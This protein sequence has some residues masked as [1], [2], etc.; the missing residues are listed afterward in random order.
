MNDSE[1]KNK[2]WPESS[3]KMLLRATFLSGPLAVNA[4]EEWK[5]QVNMDDHPDPGSSRLLPHLF[6]NL[7]DLNVDDPILM[8]LRGIARKNWVNNQRVL[9]SKGLPWRALSDQGIDVLLLPGAATALQYYSDY[10]LNPSTEIALL[11]RPNT[12]NTVVRQLQ[13]LGWTVETKLPLGEIEAIVFSRSFL[14]FRNGDG[15]HLR[16]LWRT[17][18]RDCP[19][20]IDEALWAGAALAQLQ[21][22]SV[23]V[24]NP[25]D[26][27]L[28]ASSQGLP[29]VLDPLFVRAAETMMVLKA[30]STVVDWS[31]LITQAQIRWQRIPLIEVL[32]YLQDALDIPI[33][34]DA[35]PRLQKTPLFQSEQRAYN[36]R[37]YK[38][39]GWRKGIALWYEQSH[40]SRDDHWGRRIVNFPRYLQRTWQLKSVWKVP[41][42][43]FSLLLHKPDPTSPAGR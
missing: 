29:H 36:F 25:T 6:H 11:L 41:L 7:R 4:W 16:M 28:W 8:K 21:N 24:L 14:R 15:L 20:E 27:V 22:T 23:Y 31:R 33:P 43:A 38:A 26:H 37:Q 18:P 30:I 10:V 35:L 5:A 1:E 34:A 12:V 40:C 32:L 9:N 19:D 39:K 17:M 2:L 3:H 42:H 13:A